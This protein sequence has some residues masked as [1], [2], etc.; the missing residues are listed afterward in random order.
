MASH[1]HMGTLFGRFDADVVLPRQL[2]PARHVNRQLGQRG[3]T[4]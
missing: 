4:K 1:E 2:D 3:P